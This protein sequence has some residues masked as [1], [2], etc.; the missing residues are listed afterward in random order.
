MNRKFA[1]IHVVV[2]DETVLRT[3]DLSAKDEAIA[4]GEKIFRD[5]IGHTVVCGII[6]VDDAGER[7]GTSIQIFRV[8]Q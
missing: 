7:V 5:G 2:N 4:C 8:W 6:P 1:I 3:F